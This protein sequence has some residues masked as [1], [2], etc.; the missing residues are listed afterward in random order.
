MKRILVTSAADFIQSDI[1]EPKITKE[2]APLKQNSAQE[3][4]RTISGFPGVVES[5][6][7]PLLHFAV[8]F[9]SFSALRLNWR[10]VLFGS[11]IAMTPDLDVLFHVHRSVSHSAITLA[12]IVIPI[13]L[14]S[15]KYPTLRRFT[16]IA[17]AGIT[18]H[19]IMDLFTNYT[20][21]LYP[22]VNQSF[23]ISISLGV[24]MRSFPIFTLTAKLLTQPATFGAFEFLNATAV[25][26]SGVGI[27]LVMLTPILV[28]MIRGKSIRTE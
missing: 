13:L 18:T 4:P 7:E 3:Q 23:W 16:L 17:G 20:P 15:R 21:L 24:Q 1:G 26:P 8:P 12:L 19:L 6:P 10:E 28:N 22:L 9:A 2:N 14:L 27:T 25:T 11:I 5:L